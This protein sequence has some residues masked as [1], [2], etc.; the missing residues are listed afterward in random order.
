MSKK[1]AFIGYL[2]KRGR[3]KKWEEDTKKIAR[4][5]R[6][7]QKNK[8]RQGSGADDRKRK[9]DTIIEQRQG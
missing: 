3:N 5:Q 4:K 8:K 9:G 1:Y 2:R 7:K 6:T